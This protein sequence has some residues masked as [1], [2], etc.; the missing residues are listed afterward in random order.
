PAQLVE[1]GIAC[2]PKAEKK[3]EPLAE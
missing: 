2:L 3:E 1:L